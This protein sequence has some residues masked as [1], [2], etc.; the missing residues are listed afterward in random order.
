MLSGKHGETCVEDH[1]FRVFINS[2]QWSDNLLDFVDFAGD[3]NQEPNLPDPKSWAELA[4]Y[5][6]GRDVPRHVI[7]SAKHIYDLFV[8]ETRDEAS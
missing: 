7:E 8:D 5:I 6:V 2:R 4:A 3:A 1:K